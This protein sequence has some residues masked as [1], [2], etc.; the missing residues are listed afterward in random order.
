[1][2]DFSYGTYSI[3]L[4]PLIGAYYTTDYATYWTTYVGLTTDYEITY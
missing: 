4:S 2:Y 3:L 1:M